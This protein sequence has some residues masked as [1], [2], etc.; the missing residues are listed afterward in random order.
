M[1]AVTLHLSVIDDG[2][3]CLLAC[4]ARRFSRSMKGRGLIHWKPQIVVKESNPKRRKVREAL[5]IHR[6]G[7]KAMNQDKGT[8]ISKLGLE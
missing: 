4:F 8:N 7:E 3:F 5:K 1:L 6:L 2:D